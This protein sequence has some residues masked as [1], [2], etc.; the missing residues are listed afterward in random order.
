MS[1]RRGR[2]LWHNGK[3]ARRCLDW[4]RFARKDG[5]AM[6]SGLLWHNG[7]WVRFVIFFISGKFDFRRV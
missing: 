5:V 3:W 1:A 4:I 6:H 7:K 2:L